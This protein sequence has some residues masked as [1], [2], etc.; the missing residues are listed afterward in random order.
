MMKNLPQIRA[1][2]GGDGGVP[3]SCHGHFPG[4][5]GWVCR[6]LSIESH[7]A[8]KMF[9]YLVLRDVIS[10]ANRLAIVGPRMAV[11]TQ[12]HLYPVVDE[13]LKQ[14][15]NKGVEQAVQSHPVLDIIQGAHDQLYSRLFNS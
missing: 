9:L 8:E 15:R 14:A 5:F 12:M 11:A 10:A 1:C 6:S 2:T 7:T 3:G 4:L 13:A